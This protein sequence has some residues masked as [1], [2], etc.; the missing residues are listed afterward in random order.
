MNKKLNKEQVRRG[1]TLR[2]GIWRKILLPDTLLDCAR[3]IV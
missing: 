3:S 1:A 2:E